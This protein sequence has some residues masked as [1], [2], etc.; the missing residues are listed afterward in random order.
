MKCIERIMED[1]QRDVFPIDDICGI[2]M[3]KTKVNE[4]DAMRVSIIRKN[5]S[6]RIDQA[7][8][9][10]N[11][12]DNYITMAYDFYN[13]LKRYVYYEGHAAWKTMEI[14]MSNPDG[15]VII[16]YKD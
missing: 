10:T 16:K 15:N 7:F 13:E 14:N 1:C 11:N 9:A 4:N 8:I 2:E 12:S 5:S 3:R 6:H